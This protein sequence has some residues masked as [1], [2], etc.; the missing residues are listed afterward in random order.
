MIRK[1]AL[2]L[3][4]AL[5]LTFGTAALPVLGSAPAYAQSDDYMAPNSRIRRP[6]QF[7]TE[8]RGVPQSEVTE[9]TRRRS[10]GMVDHFA[11]CLWDRSNEKGLDLLTRTD[12]GFYTFEQI[13][14][15][16]DEI[17]D[18]YPIQTCLSRVASRNYSGVQL[19]YNASSMRRWYIQ[20]AYLDYFEDGATW[21]QP[22]YE[23]AERVYPL[24]MM[25][26]EV[27]AA[28]NL[29]DC[30]VAGDPHGADLY[31]RTE[32]G[33]AEETAALHALV[34][35]IGNCV[36]ANVDFELDPYAMRVWLG[37]GLWHASQNSV[38]VVAEAGE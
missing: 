36:P 4:G 25:N 38:P 7:P 2:Y 17:R 5:A 9:V 37:E 13:G 31:Y 19:T 28:M 23:I 12:F 16:N 10:L 8:P 11:N 20:G 26:G 1:V 6:R 14:I 27:Q 24:S 33:S 30:I 3:F 22:G 21:V 18:Y 35:A 15:A 32:P 29:A 34:P